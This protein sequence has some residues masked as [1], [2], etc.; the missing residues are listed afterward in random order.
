M[1]GDSIPDQTSATPASVDRTTPLEPALAA[2]SK[3][4]VAS[5]YGHLSIID[6]KASSLLTFNAIGLTAISIWLEYVPLNFLHLTLDGIFVALLASCILCLAAVFLYWVRDDRLSD[7]RFIGILKKKIRIRTRVY[8][9]AWSLSLASVT[10]L[11]VVSSLHMYDSYLQVT[12]LCNE[13]C[14]SLLDSEQWRN[15]DYQ[16]R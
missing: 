2:L 3:D 5:L 12:Q 4:T 14:E 8:V 10:L 6:S 7:P 1:S 15:L 16:A 9:C 13:D 11:I